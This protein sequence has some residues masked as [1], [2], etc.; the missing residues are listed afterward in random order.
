MVC[1][2]NHETKPEA[3]HGEEQSTHARKS[4]PR[5]L[6][7][8]LRVNA[9]AVVFRGENLAA[10]DGANHLVPHL[11]DKM[12]GRHNKRSENKHIKGET[13]AP[14]SIVAGSI[15]FAVVFVRDGQP[16]HSVSAGLSASGGYFQ[17]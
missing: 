7:L 12:L 17:L 16:Q 1:V 4:S 14:R 8:I 13:A 9:R 5:E 2:P 10:L 6:H 15:G 11:G 3:D